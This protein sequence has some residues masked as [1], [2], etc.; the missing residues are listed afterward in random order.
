M[1]GV[2]MK[3]LYLKCNS[4]TQ[5]EGEDFDN[6]FERS[7]RIT[8]IKNCDLHKRSRRRNQNWQKMLISD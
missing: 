1:V 3:D 4:R 7:I 6:F 8:N 5:K 2:Y